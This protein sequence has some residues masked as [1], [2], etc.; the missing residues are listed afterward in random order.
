M[1]I[2]GIYLQD[3]YIYKKGKSSNFIIG[4]NFFHS[5]NPANEN[6]RL[7]NIISEN[8]KNLILIGVGNGSLLEY[9]SQHYS[10]KKIYLIEPVQNFIPFQLEEIK[11]ITNIE[12]NY[13]KSIE[14]FLHYEIERFYILIHP[15]YKRFFPYIV[16]LIQSF[17]FTEFDKKTYYKHLNFIINNY[18]Q[19]LLKDKIQF[20][21]YIEPIPSQILFFGGG[22]TLINDIKEFK[23][24]Y[25]FEDFFIISSDTAIPILTYLFPDIKINLV[26]STDPN[27]STLFHINY[28]KS[29]KNIIPILSWLGGRKEI[30]KI[31][32]CYYFLTSFPIDQIIEYKFQNQKILS[33]E[34]PTRDV[35][36]YIMN[37][38][39]KW[40]SSLFFLGCGIQKTNLKQFYSKGT[41]YDFYQ[42]LK[43]KRISSA[44]NYHYYLFKN[45][46]Y[47]IQN[48][49]LPEIKNKIIKSYDKFTIHF[50][51]I[52][53]S[54]IIQTLIQ[55]FY[56][57]NQYSYELKRLY[58]LLK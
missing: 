46:Y 38:A 29:K 4:R 31:S 48:R 12:I 53:T 10:I 13:I 8:I 11:K 37:L 2:P 14:E 34:N 55:N 17:L 20:F 40:N 21:S 5:Q 7:K 45:Q 16:S 57:L 28:L 32:H 54:E 51:E 24:K 50:Q 6:L 35:L 27:Y 43:Q 39:E 52:S 9:I 44:E 25:N 19:N 36:G 41:G 18:Y 49:K 26:I 3:F 1:L 30:P 23:N 58:H 15:Q 47:K 22:E 42:I 56:K 33:L